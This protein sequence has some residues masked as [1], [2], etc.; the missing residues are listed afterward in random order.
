MRFDVLTLFPRMFESPLSESI[1][2]KARNREQVKVIVHNIRDFAHGR[3][4]VVDDTPYGGG[5]G[6]VM[7]PEPVVRAIES[8]KKNH[9]SARVILM[10]PQGSLLDDSHV[11]RLVQYPHLVLM[12]GRYEGV[13]ER[14]RLG[15]VDEEISIGDYVLTGGELA[16]MVV[17]DAVSRQLDGFLGNESAAR[18]DSFSEGLLEYP[19]YTKPRNFRGLRVP[20]ILIS[21]NHKEIRRWRRKESIRK[22][23]LRRPDLLKKS[24]LSAEDCKTLDEIEREGRLCKGMA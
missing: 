3:H 5:G 15:F 1:L 17:I 7:K 14:V 23:W 12:C 13:D 20:E 6:M 2:Q 10:T 8:I 19:Q 21:G 11:C 4:R 16:A 9:P 22:T 24:K 18:D